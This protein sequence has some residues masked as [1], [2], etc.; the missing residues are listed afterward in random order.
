MQ[1]PAHFAADLP[2]TLELHRVLG[3]KMM[4]SITPITGSL[5]DRTYQLGTGTLFRVGDFSFLVTAAHVLKE[6]NEFNYLMRILDAKAPDGRVSA[7]DLPKWTAEIADGLVDVAVMPLS[8]DIVAALPNRTFLHL[9][10]VAMRVTEPG[11]CWVMGYPHEKVR[12]AKKRTQM[13]LN[14]FL[15]AAPTIQWE[16]TLNKFDERF[17][18][19]LD[20][21]RDELWW[22]HGTPAK[23]PRK[24]QGIS[25]CPVWQVAWPDGAWE[26]DHARIVGV[27]IGYYRRRSAVKATH[28]GA[29]MKL[30]YDSY[31][32]LRDAIALHL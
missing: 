28:W 12:Y 20:A 21:K 13:T 23:L 16:E 6:I 1:T 30:L 14:P 9:Y 2:K 3:P 4:A 5:T 18:F 32:N 31:P 10:E 27:Q 19:L 25:G 7:V 8:E 11:G 26:P 24:L 22:P 15:L 29:V 17:H